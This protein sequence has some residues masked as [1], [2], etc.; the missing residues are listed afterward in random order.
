[1]KPLFLFIL[2]SAGTIGVYSC[3]KHNDNKPNKPAPNVIATVND[4]C[5][6]NQ[7]CNYNTTSVTYKGGIFYFSAADTFNSGTRNVGSESVWM[8]VRVTDTGKIAFI[9]PNYAGS[10]G[11]GFGALGPSYYGTTDSTS[12]GSVIFT[13]FDTIKHIAS[14]TFSYVTQSPP[15]SMSNGSSVIQNGTF[16]KLTW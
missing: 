14:G 2:F 15:M 7:T 9:I 13:Q 16:T 10:S 12:M 8:N 5:F 3:T 4:Q 6:N 1:M 11:G